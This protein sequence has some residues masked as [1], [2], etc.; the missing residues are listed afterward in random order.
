MGYVRVWQQWIPVLV[1]N[2]L[3]WSLQ[4]SVYGMELDRGCLCPSIRAS[5]LHTP[6][7]RPHS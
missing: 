7:Q 1:R 4:D 2:K 5:A 6:P 3:E